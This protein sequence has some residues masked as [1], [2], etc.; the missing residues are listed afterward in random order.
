MR[1]VRLDP[2]LTFMDA[3]RVRELN[4]LV[5]RPANDRNVRMAEIRARL[6]LGQLEAM[7]LLGALS[8][9]EVSK[10]E[11]AVFHECAPEV[12]ATECDL[13]RRF[14][15][16]PFRCPNCET[17]VESEDGLYFLL[18]CRLVENFIVDEA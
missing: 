15:L 12:P 2:D 6:G 10:F 4:E 5:R 1:R 17:L 16:V 11:L 8:A 13:D 14:Q 9:S 18:G 7:Q 3:R